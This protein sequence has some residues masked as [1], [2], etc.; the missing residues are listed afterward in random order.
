MK[1][2]WKYIHQVGKQQLDILLTIMTLD[3]REMFQIKVPL[4]SGC[5]GSC[6]DVAFVKKTT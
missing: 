4:D 2:P 3:T 5:T 1:E 6:I